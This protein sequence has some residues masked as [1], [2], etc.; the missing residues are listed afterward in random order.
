MERRMS[1]RRLRTV[2]RDQGCVVRLKSGEI[3]LPDADLEFET[4]E[5]LVAAFRHMVR[6]Q[7]YDVCEMALTTY[8]CAR[9]HGAPIT[10][11]PAFI[12]RG[13][14]HGAMFRHVDRPLSDLRD[15]HG[16]RVGVSRGYTVTTGVWARA[17]LSEEHGVDPA[18]VTWVRSSDEHV[19]TYR[20]PANVETTDL[21]LLDLVRSGELDAVVGVEPPAD[22]M[23]SLIPDARHAA[24]RALRER[25]AYPINHLV[26]IRDEL[27][28]EHPSLGA[29]LLAAIEASTRLQ[30]ES[31]RAGSTLL[32]TPN[33]DLH[34]QVMSAGW[35]DPL[36]FGVDDNI[37]VL[38]RLVDHA[39][40]QGILQHRPALTEVFAAGTC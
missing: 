2:L 37:E 9:E 22:D 10:A 15:L 20:P 31:L 21:P 33:D 8:L 35:A 3:T 36:P 5:P 28:R 30:V 38:E 6:E 13:L 29:E 4:V 32:E 39:M 1:R 26:V 19:E 24:E 23:T 11:I 12:A 14:H 34:R 16:R 7:R 40:T 27:L 18:L 25:G 17:I